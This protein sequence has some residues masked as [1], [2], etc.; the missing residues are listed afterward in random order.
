MLLANYQRHLLWPAE[1]FAGFQQPDPYLAPSPG[2]HQEWIQACKTG[3]P[4]LCNFDYSGAVTEAVLLGNVA[5]R[6]GKRIKWDAA[7]LRVTNEPEANQYLQR[8]Y[9]RGWTV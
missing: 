9:R 3:S 5:Y 6:C 8:E 2:H 4:T 7:N 1:Q